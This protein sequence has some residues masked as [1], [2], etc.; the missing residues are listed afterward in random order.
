MIL[1]LTV[2]FLQL[3]A[4]QNAI[5]EFRAADKRFPA[6]F[7]GCTHWYCAVIGSYTGSSN[8]VLGLTVPPLSAKTTATKAKLSLEKKHDYFAIIP[9]CSHSY[10]LTEYAKIQLVEAPL[11]STLIV[12]HLLLCVHVVIKTLNLEI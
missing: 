1:E 5:C 3:S 10:L 8:F 7:T 4:N 12:R 2:L 11:N 9:S 6:L